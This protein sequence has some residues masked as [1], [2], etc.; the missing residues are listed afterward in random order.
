MTGSSE[1]SRVCLNGTTYGEDSR[2]RLCTNAFEKSSR[3]ASNCLCLFRE[4]LKSLTG[5]EFGF[6]A[7]ILSEPMLVCEERVGV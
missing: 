5:N 6:T 2:G 7:S 3:A 4:W 1:W